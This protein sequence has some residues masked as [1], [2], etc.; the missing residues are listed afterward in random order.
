VDLQDQH[1]H[2]EQLRAKYETL[3]TLL[4]PE[5]RG[6]PRVS[7][8]FDDATH[9]TGSAREHSTTAADT[10]EQTPVAAGTPGG[11]AY[12]E[13]DLYP[14]SLWKDPEYARLVSQASEATPVA[15]LAIAAASMTRS[16]TQH[17]TDAEQPSSALRLLAQQ[18][19]Q[20]D[21]YPVHGDADDHA[22][23]AGPGAHS[24]ALTATTLF[25]S[26]MLSAKASFTPARFQ[27]RLLQPAAKAGAKAITTAT[28]PATQ[29]AVLST[30]Q[31]ATTA[32]GKQNPYNS[33]N[34]TCSTPPVGPPGM[35]YAQ[36]ALSAKMHGYSA[37]NA[38]LTHMY[39]NISAPATYTHD[40]FA[41]Y[42][43]G[44]RGNREQQPEQAM[45]VASTPV[46]GVSRV[47]KSG[48]APNGEL[49]VHGSAFAPDLSR[50]DALLA[51]SRSI[52]TSTA[53][54]L[55]AAQV[56]GEYSTIYRLT[57]NFAPAGGRTPAD[58]SMLSG[59]AGN[60]SALLDTSSTSA[61]SLQR[62]IQQLTDS[63]D[64]LLPPPP[65]PSQVQFTQRQ[66][67][68]G[69]ATSSHSLT[70]MPGTSP[71]DWL[72]NALAQVPQ[73]A[74]GAGYNSAHN[75]NATGTVRT[76][77]RNATQLSV[78]PPTPVPQ[79]IVHT[80]AKSRSHATP[81]TTDLYQQ[82]N[83]TDPCDSPTGDET[84]DRLAQQ[85]SSAVELGSASLPTPPPRAAVPDYL[86]SNL[87]QW[88]AE[89]EQ[90]QTPELH[91]ASSVRTDQVRRVRVSSLPVKVTQQTQSVVSVKRTTTTPPGSTQ[92]P[93]K[94]VRQAAS[95]AN[96]SQ[97]AHSVIIP[98]SVLPS[99]QAAPVHPFAHKQVRYGSELRS[100]ALGSNANT[101]TSVALEPRP[102]SGRVFDARGG[103]F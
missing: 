43:S 11:I 49:D 83:P 74:S 87:K 27:E 44:T 89:G 78:K 99:P 30:P 82:N 53:P 77:L 22:P 16:Q 60:G 8:S 80:A 12:R 25:A 29:P 48:S 32:A 41:S 92:K 39:P 7:D 58:E 56:G 9:Y 68:P 96:A 15:A 72:F 66:V 98:N 55:S 6:I 81:A 3:N 76:P 37:T 51:H 26:P 84:I 61:H 103:S 45:D 64:S 65:P 70:S 21:R 34:S 13:D 31:R 50:M 5:D 95:T 10:T 62:R 86:L 102:L 69:A 40:A 57:E 90:S 63:Q 54:R 52:A 33:V 47:P 79:Y 94:T 71:S 36:P 46:S 73:P 28:V 4:Q 35:K 38:N 93:W 1:K 88:A 85:F 24:T 75:A 20:D 14:S 100:P 91:G 2:Y 42:L 101:P 23:Y 19:A 97:E 59:T 17:D 67:L 18:Y